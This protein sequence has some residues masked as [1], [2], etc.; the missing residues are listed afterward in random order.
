[1]T[2]DLFKEEEGATPLTHEEKL[3]LIPTYITK[4]SELNEAEQ[5]N[6]TE[7]ERWAFSRSRDILDV[8]FLIALHQQML[9]KI[10][11]WAGDYSRENNRRLGSDSYRIPVDLKALVDDARAWVEYKSFPADEIALRFHHRLTQIH[12][13]PN[14]NG[15]FSR[16]AADLLIKQLGGDIFTWGRVNLVNAGDTRTAYIDTLKQADGHDYGPLI[17]FARS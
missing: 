14:G 15:R 9:G 6:I 5:I 3:G 1:V 12:P 2:D 11:H 17:K 7:G 10:W 16:L 8:E 13:F 4:R